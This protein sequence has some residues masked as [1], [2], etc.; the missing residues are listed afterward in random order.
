MPAKGTASA[1]CRVRL[2][3]SAAG[4]PSLLTPYVEAKRCFC[5]GR[6]ALVI[7]RIDLGGA[8]NL[9]RVLISL[10]AAPKQLECFPMLNEWGFALKCADV[11]S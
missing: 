1:G 10:T 9:M 4:T 3:V 2:A 7:K 6:V 5:S 11:I 8:S